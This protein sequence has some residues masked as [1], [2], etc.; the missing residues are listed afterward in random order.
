M[1][2]VTKHYNLPTKLWLARLGK[3][4]GALHTPG[5]KRAGRTVSS[6]GKN[7]M[8]KRPGQH[9]FSSVLSVSLLLGAGCAAAAQE[10]HG[11]EQMAVD[12][13][14]AA[15]RTMLWSDAAA[16][17]DGKVPAEG[18]AVVIGRGMD[19]VLDIDPPPLR[20]LTIDGKLSFSD[21]LDIELETDWIYLRRGEL[22]IG[23]EERPHRHKATITLT[24][25]VPGENINTMGDRGILLM[26]GT[27]SLHGDRENSLDQAGANRR[28]GSTRIEVLDASGWR[29]G[30]EIVLASTDFDPRQAEKRTIAA[31]EG[32]VITLD[33]AAG[34][35]AFR[36][37]HLRGRPARRSRPA[38]AQCPHPGIAGRGKLIL[39]RA[40]HGDARPDVR[41]SGVELYRMGQHL[42]LARYPIHWHL[43]GEGQGQYIRNSAIHDTY[44]RCVTVHGT[45]NVRVENNVTFNTVGHCFFLEDAVET[46]NQFIRNLG[47]MTKC[48][49]TLPCEPTHLG[50]AGLSTSGRGAAGQRS[51]HILIASDNTASTFWITNPDNIYRDNVA[52]GSDMVGFWFA[53]PVH[54]TGAV[55]RHG[56]QR[57]HLA[58]PDPRAR[59]QRQHR[60]LQL[61][62][63]DVRSRPQSRQHLQR[64]RQ[65]LPFPHP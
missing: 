23:S 29:P 31:I 9:L 64:R 4:S 42:T 37:D 57:Q 45:N 49:P 39:R 44:N 56:D 59:V 58:A 22:H 34:L 60:P 11:H 55:R 28:A 41:L 5:Q 38:D 50:P 24:D 48:H 13:P 30:D 7:V 16:W 61:R 21:D 32:N 46:G 17:P 15:A 54:P 25:T 2:T 52:A 51:E 6:E 65:Q 26:G 35:H 14:E 53:L 10:H 8:R 47:I 27:L 43:I 20:S 19:V 18:D 12:A 3:R 33:R 62:R 40:Y 1:P 36:R 63:P